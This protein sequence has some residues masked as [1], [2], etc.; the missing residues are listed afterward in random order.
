[1]PWRAMQNVSVVNGCMFGWGCEP[2]VGPFVDG[3]SVVS[4][5]DGP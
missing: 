5:V 4:A 1:M 3:S 2:P